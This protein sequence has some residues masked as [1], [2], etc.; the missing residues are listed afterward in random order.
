MAKPH[1]GLDIGTGSLKL[2]LCDEK[3]VRRL[4]VEA[5]PDNLVREGEIVSFEAMAD[6]IKETLRKHRIAARR[7]AMILPTGM[8]FLRRLTMPVMDVDQLRINLPYEFRD[9]VTAS[10]DQYFYDYAVNEI[11]QGEEEGAAGEMDLLAAAVSKQVVAEYRE[12]CRRAGLKLRIAAPTECAYGNLI[13]AYT[14]EH[15]DQAGQE[16]CILDLGH[17]ATRLHIYT[18]SRFEATRVVEIGGTTVDS[19]IA[20]AMSVDEHVARTYKEANHE[21]AQALEEPRSVYTNIAIEVMKAINFY[22]FNNRESDLQHIYYCGGSAKIGL[23]LD[24]IAETG[25]LRRQTQTTGL[26]LHNIE[27]L[28]PP[29]EGDEKPDAGLCAAAVGITMQ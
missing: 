17:A 4:A 13:H 6:F 26:T 7:C 15:P 28:L 5:L 8:A 16:Y 2:A 29:I 23:L 14:L 21:K 11:R 24:A 9:Y 22:G 20:G 27:E 18:G 25:E 3:G 1:L 12:M 10:K 19:A